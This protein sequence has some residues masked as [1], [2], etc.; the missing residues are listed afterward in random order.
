MLNKLLANNTLMILIVAAI[1]VIAS[2]LILNHMFQSTMDGIEWEE[3]IHR[4]KSGE[5]LWSIAG[6]YCPDEVDRRE[7]IAEIQSLNDLPDSNIR[8][9]QKLIVLAPV[10]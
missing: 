6:E 10:K 8:A 4:V 3:T 5:S 7:W 9:G 1:I 2:V